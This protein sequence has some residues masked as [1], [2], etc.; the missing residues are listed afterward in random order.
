MYTHD[1]RKK[2]NNIDEAGPSRS[3]AKVVK[4]LHY[5]VHQ[6]LNS[7]STHNDKI[8]THI[9]Q[10]CTPDTWVNIYPLYVR[11]PAEEVKILEDNSPSGSLSGMSNLSSPLRVGTVGKKNGAEVGFTTGLR[12]LF[13]AW[14]YKTPFYKNLLENCFNKGFVRAWCCSLYSSKECKS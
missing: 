6:T 10:F 1:A 14:K 13:L 3:K 7:I 9:A 11:V 4:V 12:G 5:W 2:N 8:K